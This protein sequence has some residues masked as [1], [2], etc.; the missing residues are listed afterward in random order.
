MAICWLWLCSTAIITARYY[1]LVFDSSTL[2][3]A[4]DWFN[5]STETSHMLM[6]HLQLSQCPNG[7]PITWC[8]CTGSEIQAAC[9]L[10]LRAWCALALSLASHKGCAKPFQYCL[11]YHI[12]IVFRF[13]II[14]PKGWCHTSICGPCGRMVH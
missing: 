14:Y 8:I 6:S 11:C 3:N 10:S 1:K 7:Q 5:V 12:V 13:P 2:L 4:Q 9:H